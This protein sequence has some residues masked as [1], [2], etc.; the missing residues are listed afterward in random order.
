MRRCS[1]MVAQSLWAPTQKKGGYQR[2]EEC[3]RDGAPAQTPRRMQVPGRK[4]PKQAPGGQSFSRGG[5]SNMRTDNAASMIMRCIVPLCTAACRAGG[6]DHSQQAESSSGRLGWGRKAG[7]L[8]D[9]PGAMGARRPVA[10]PV[11]R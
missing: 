9:A 2:D 7:S 11:W 6:R 8:S 1:G 5:P 4:E 3:F 10:A